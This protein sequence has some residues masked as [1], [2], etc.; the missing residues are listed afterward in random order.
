MKSI[1]ET[2]LRRALSTLLYL[3][4]IP[5]APGTVGSAVTI[6][7]LLYFKDDVNRWF[8]P[9]NIAFFLLFY[10]LFLA[11]GFWLCNDTEKNFSRADPGAV[12]IDEV[13][14]QI[15]TFFMLPLSMSTALMG[16]VLF[17]F[18]DIVKPWP[19]NVFETTEGGVGIMMDDVAAG[20]MACI[21]LHAIRW[22]Y[23]V[24]MAAI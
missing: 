15:I 19:V 18:F 6:M 5:G 10:V 22:G 3:G 1:L 20:I 11:V 24:V 7:A 13:A 16:F 12:I 8:L 2:S 14:G 23:H 21:S 4:T 9:E 17:R